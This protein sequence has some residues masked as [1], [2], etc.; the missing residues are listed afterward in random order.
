MTRCKF[1]KWV[2]GLACAS[3][4][5]FA[6]K[7][8]VLASQN[9]AI[10]TEE[11]ASNYNGMVYFQ[12]CNFNEFGS[13]PIGGMILAKFNLNIYSGWVAVADGSFSNGIN[14]AVEGG[15][16][17]CH[18][19]LS[20][21]SAGT[22]TWQNF[23]GPTDGSYTNVIGPKM[24]QIGPTPADSWL[25]QP[26]YGWTVSQS[27]I[28]AWLDNPGRCYGIALVPIEPGNDNNQCFA[29]LAMNWEPRQQPKL[30]IDVIVPEPTV[31]LGA[32][33]LLLAGRR[34]G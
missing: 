29:M 19:V 6:D 3:V 17:G 26:P 12:V 13:A 31:G 32:L 1:T 5:V 22:V 14:W 4:T 20:N 15:Y 30:V 7:V 9:A 18:P 2:I 16:Y 33:A 34:R 11:P 27:V 24:S 10:K 28:Q 21:W 25:Q 23:I 8:V